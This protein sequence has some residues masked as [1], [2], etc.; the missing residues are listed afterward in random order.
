MAGGSGDDVQEGGAG[1]D[2]I[3]ANAGVDVSRGGDGDDVLW[4]LARS[5]VHPGANGAVDQVGDTL[6]GGNGDD[7]F[8]TRDGEV[9]RITCGDGTDR[10]FVDQV[11]V[12]TDATA[13]NPDGSC[14]TVIRKAAKAADS[15][16]EDREQTTRDEKVAA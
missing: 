4:A 15:R 9:V 6:E 5:D 13:Q 12:I 1:N 10:A 14:E 3:F 2:V 16:S 7:R 8:R 11:D